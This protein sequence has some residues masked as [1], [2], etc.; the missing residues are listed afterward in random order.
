[1]AKITL[2]AE[3]LTR[4]SFK[5]YGDVIEIDNASHFSI[6]AGNVERFHD[7]AK[8]SIDSEAG[9]RPQISIMQTN[10]ATKLPARVAVVER[11]PKG[12]QAFYPLFDSPLVIVVAKA[13]DDFKVEDLKAFVTNG[14]QGYNFQPGTWHMPL[15]TPKVGQQMFIVDRGGPG[16]NC[17]ELRLENEEIYVNV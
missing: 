15:I 4:E 8:V 1:M 17:D 10:T 6:N 7:L 5:A 16:D 14:Q 11:H 2:K 13:T 3:P 12:S 9:G